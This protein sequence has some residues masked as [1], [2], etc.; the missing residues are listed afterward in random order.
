MSARGLARWMALAGN[1][2]LLGSLALILVW[3][4]ISLQLFVAAWLVYGI[5]WMA[6]A[7][8]ADQIFEMAPSVWP[9][10]QE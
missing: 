3:W 10:V 5:A 4:Q 9:P 2:L 8:V 6:E 7:A 1:A